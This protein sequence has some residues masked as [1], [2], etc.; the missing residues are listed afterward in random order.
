MTENQLYSS[1]CICFINSV[2]LSCLVFSTAIASRYFLLI[3]KP[4]QQTK[5]GKR[6]V[7]YILH[8]FKFDI[9]VEGVVVVVVHFIFVLA[10]VVLC[11]FPFP[12]FAIVFSAFS[13]FNHFSKYFW[14]CL[15]SIYVYCSWQTHSL[16][17]SPI[18]WSIYFF[19]G[20]DS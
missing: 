6:I 3:M 18:Y 15:F 9:A 5:R 8:D 13:H 20:L 14:P 10:L 2:T 16:L 4:A 11:I 19:V 12:Y 17:F 7:T 1:R